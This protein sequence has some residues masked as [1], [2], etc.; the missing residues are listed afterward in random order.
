MARTAS[1]AAAA[2]A[3]LVLT[4]CSDP[5]APT[6]SVSTPSVSTPS[7][8][9]D[10]E[11]GPSEPAPSEPAPSSP[12]P[13]ERVD[14]SAWLTYSTHDGDM[15]YRYP[16]DWTL[17]SEST[18][19]SPDAGR[20]DVVDPYERWMDSSTLTAPNGQRL[21]ASYDFVDIGGA[22][23][24]EHRLPIEVLAT[25]PASAAPLT[26]GEETVIATVAVARPDGR[27]T[28]GIGVTSTDHLPA[29]GVGCGVYLVA[30]SSDGGFSI[31]THLTVG[32]YEETDAL[33]TIAS[34]DDAH[35]Y[36]QTAEYATLLE[37]LRSVR[38]S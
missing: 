15:T 37:I 24:P 11:R 5:A 10:P 13:S 25:E 22:C 21:L 23:P 1:I 17:T 34:L 28:F 38:T 9:P 14:T 8:D 27:W 30:A 33:W 26:D 7:A 3:L 32:S 35:A 19:A 18:F 36:M 4:A 2:L 20:D 16:A 29:E 31:G 12:A 6:P